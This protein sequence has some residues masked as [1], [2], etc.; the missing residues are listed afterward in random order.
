MTIRSNLDVAHLGY[1]E[2]FTP[3]FD[4]SLRFFTDVLSMEVV[5]SVEDTSYLRAWDDYERFSL[6][7]TARSEAGIGRVGVRASD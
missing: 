3:T 1:V 6:K 7:L 4:E 2:L 5:D